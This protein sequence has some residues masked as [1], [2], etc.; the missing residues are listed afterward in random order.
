MSDSN[1]KELEETIIQIYS[2]NLNFFNKNHQNIYNKIITFEKENK[3]EYS[4]IFDNNHFDIKDKKGKYIYNCNPYYDAQCR[5]NDLEK[6]NGFLM[7]KIQE[8]YQKKKYENDIL[9]PYVILND[10]IK[11]INNKDIKKSGKFIFLGSILGAHIT[12]IIKNYPFEL[13]LLI[14][15]SIEIFRLSMFIT[16]YEDLVINHNLLLSINETNKQ[17]TINYFLNFLPKYNNKIKFEL[18]SEKEIYLIEEISNLLLQENEL[19]YPFSEYLISYTRGLK[20]LKEGY[21]LLKLNKIHSI[22]NLKP[23]LY[24]GAGL[25]LEKE[26]DFILKNQKK[27]I[28]ACVGASLKILEKYDVIPDIIISSDSSILIETQF[29]INNK[30]F[31]NSIIFLSNKTHPNVINLFNKNN[32][33]LFNDSL[34][35]FSDTGVNTGFNVGNI[36]YSI[37]LKLGVKEI[38]LLG[39]DACIDKVSGL[40]HSSKKER[41]DYKH[42]DLLKNERINSETHLIQV[43]GNFKETVYTTNHFLGMINS[44]SDSK[45]SYDISAYNLSNGALF[46]GIKPLEISKVRTLSEINKNEFNK[47]AISSLNKISKTTITFIEEK[48]LNTEKKIILKFKNLDEDD[49]FFSYENLLNNNIHDSLLFQIIK[50]YFTLVSPYYTYSLE[51][52]R[53]ATILLLKKHHYAL[54]NYFENNFILTANMQ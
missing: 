8:E 35:V 26:I 27:F 15:D 53:N 7:I 51:I 11:L 3:Y 32:I 12:D 22:V 31:E 50:K 4:L 44:F 28:I 20:Y 47:I 48:R 16:D 43:A 40:S 5:G 2:K 18:A 49:L 34:E 17:N 24:L 19:N 46:E 33:Y 41:I 36:G 14:E 25:S 45:R 29:D 52:N 39:F 30:Y 21:K 37:L 38:Y 9:D 1:I 6:S 54:I 13:Y 10:Y 23:I 42:F